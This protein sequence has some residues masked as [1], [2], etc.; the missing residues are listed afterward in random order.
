MSR[1]RALLPTAHVSPGRGLEVAENTTSPATALAGYVPAFSSPKPSNRSSPPSAESRTSTRVN[2][3]ELHGLM[4][5][6]ADGD[7][8]A[9]DGVFAALEPVVARLCRHLLPDAAEAEDAAQAALLKIFLE[10]SRFNPQRDAVGWALTIAAFECRTLRQKRR[11]LREDAMT[12]GD[13]APD[14]R[15]PEADALDVEQ[16]SAFE[17]VLQEMSP[18][19]RETLCAL[20]GQINRPAVPPAT[21]RKRA[22]RALRRV[23]A[24]WRSRYG[25][26]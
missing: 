9:F 10:A 14:D 17:A 7:R 18:V 26:D 5:R 21:F 25:L 11:R 23:R 19:D 2:N 22:E 1:F 15:T 6:L 3:R 8:R 12:P 20:T 16:R 13:A 4:L 24:V